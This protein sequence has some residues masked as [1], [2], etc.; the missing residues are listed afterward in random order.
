MTEMSQLT[1]SLLVKAEGFFDGMDGER[2]ECG[3]WGGEDGKKENKTEVG[4]R[5]EIVKG[6][7]LLFPDDFP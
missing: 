7:I 2:R 1:S 5:S 6:Q 4:N 3:A